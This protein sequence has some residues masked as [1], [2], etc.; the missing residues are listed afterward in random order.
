MVENHKF[1]N[2]KTNMFC[3]RAATGSI[4][5]VDHIDD[6]GAFHKKSEINIRTTI[7][8]LKTFTDANTD[9]LLNALRFTTKHLNDPDTPANIKNLLA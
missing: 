8:Q 5:L 9:G 1:D 2:A 6:L 4:V 3:L 7:T